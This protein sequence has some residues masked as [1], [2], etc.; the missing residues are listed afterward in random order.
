MTHEERSLLVLIA[1]RMMEFEVNHD[2]REVLRKAVLKIQK[3]ACAEHSKNNPRAPQ[4]RALEEILRAKEKRGKNMPNDYTVEELERRLKAYKDDLSNRRDATSSRI[5]LEGYAV[6]IAPHLIMLFLAAR[7]VAE[8][9]HDE[10]LDCA[11][12]IADDDCE[13]H[14]RPTSERDLYIKCYAPSSFMELMSKLGYTL[15]CTV[16]PRSIP[17]LRGAAAAA[18][19]GHADSLEHLITVLEAVGEIKLYATY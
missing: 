18:S 14:Y 12:H 15:P 13:I 4:P 3:K 8:S 1:R 11:V 7:R 19:G 9:G 5:S 2:R 17:F 10:I 16:N 6:D